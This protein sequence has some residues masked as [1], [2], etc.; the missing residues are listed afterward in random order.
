MNVLYDGSRALDAG[1]PRLVP[2]YERHT[3]RGHHWGNNRQLT[4]A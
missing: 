2:Q 3:D 1:F 4:S